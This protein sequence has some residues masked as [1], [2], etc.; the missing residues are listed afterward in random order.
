MKPA[1]LRLWVGVPRGWQ[2]EMPVLAAGLLNPTDLW[3]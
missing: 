2:S 1:A 3:S